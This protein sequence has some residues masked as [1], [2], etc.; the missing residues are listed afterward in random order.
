MEI[1]CAHPLT[2]EYLGISSADPDP[3]D[4][5]NW[6]IPAHAYAD[7]PP[8][9]P[10]GQVAQRSAD[11]SAWQLVEDHRGTVYSTTTGEAQQHGDLGELPEGLTNQPRPS[12]DHLWAG[13]SWVLDAAL[14]AANLR[15]LQAGL[16]AQI[17]TAADAARRAVAGDPL[18]AVEYDRAAAEAQAFAAAGYPE[19][20]VPRT[21]AAWAING[22]SAQQAADSILAEA[23]AYTE[24]L[25]QI[26]EARLQAK[27]QVRQAMDQGDPEQAQAIAAAAIAAAAIASIA[28]AVAGVGNNAG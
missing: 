16:C 4:A 7:A 13:T 26:R 19:G 8:A 5:D 27:E 25:Y 18:R 1:Y 22:R 28:A 6:L 12:P 17:D 10:A 2:R 3:L 14:Q 9:I 23:A 11:G 20:A 24:A 15:A 21:V